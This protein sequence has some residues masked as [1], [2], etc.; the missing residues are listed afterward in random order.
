[1]VPKALNAFEAEDAKSFTVHAARIHSHMN[2]SA[3]SVPC[4]KRG[5]MC[6]ERNDLLFLFLVR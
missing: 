5:S 2:R 1:M 6:I 4:K 3:D